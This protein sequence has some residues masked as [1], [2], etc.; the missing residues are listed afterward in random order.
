MAPI[1]EEVET[2]LIEGMHNVPIDV[3]MEKG[4]VHEVVSNEMN[5]GG[6]DENFQ[7]L[8]DE[9]VEIIVV[10]EPFHHQ[11]ENELEKQPKKDE[12][13]KKIQQEEEVQQR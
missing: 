7:Y 9:D 13:T 5:T 3:D 1:V 10:Q 8:K 4:G 6:D 11:L 12:H 2:Q